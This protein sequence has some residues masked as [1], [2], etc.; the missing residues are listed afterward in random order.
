M[1]SITV[2]PSNR[3]STVGGVLIAVDRYFEN[4][5]T[6]LNQKCLNCIMGMHEDQE[7]REEFG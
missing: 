5:G 4:E 6:I 1:P 2:S 7:S 3:P